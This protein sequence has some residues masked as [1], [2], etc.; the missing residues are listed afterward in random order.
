MK[1]F[2][3]RIETVRRSSGGYRVFRVY[4]WEVKRNDIAGAWSEEYS[5]K[6]PGQAARELA[7]SLGL[8]KPGQPT[9]SGA[10]RL[11]YRE[12]FTYCGNARFKELK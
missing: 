12:G 7:E 3:F 11:E 6:D 4:L 10:H 1:T 2:F 5:F 8:F 9:Q